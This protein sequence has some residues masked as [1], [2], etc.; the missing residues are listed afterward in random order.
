VTYD[1]LVTL[2][3]IVKEGS[4]KAA[5]LKLHKS[6]PSLSMAVKKLEEEFQVKLFNRDDYR[7]KLTEEGKMFYEKAQLA[8]AHMKGLENFGQELGL[9]VEAEIKIGIEGLVP[10]QNL[11]GELG[12][13]FNKY[14]CTKFSLSV[15]YVS[16]TWEKL[17]NKE[18]DF[19]FTAIFEENED[20]ES[21]ELFEVSLI[22]VVANSLKI[23]NREDLKK[24]P[25]I[26]IKDS[27]KKNSKDFGILK[28]S[29]KW[30]VTD[31]NTKKQI[32]HS[33]LGWGRLPCYSVDQDL[34]EGRLDKIDFPG[35][36]I[37]NTRIYLASNKNTPKGPIAREFNELFGSTDFDDK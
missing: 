12:Q 8:L 22:P 11:L 37:H 35:I 9:G 18:I 19:A 29:R 13:F 10:I 1:Q 6:Q 34:K 2:D 21:R 5:A 32:I 33:G 15:D 20:V 36:D 4:F 26:I 3:A 14:E 25:Q 17:L 16:G 24:L 28:D 23:K 31:F 30:Y 7:P 27:A